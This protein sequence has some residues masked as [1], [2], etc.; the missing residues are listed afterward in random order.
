MLRIFEMPSLLVSHAL[1]EA[2]ELL[3]SVLAIRAVSALAARNLNVCEEA[4]DQGVLGN[5]QQ[6]H[7]NTGDDV[8]NDE[9][10][11]ERWNGAV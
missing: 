1:N 9:D 2:V 7:V 3:R 11:N 5:A 6:S 10:A 4:L 8:A